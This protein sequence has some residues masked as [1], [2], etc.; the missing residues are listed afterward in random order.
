MRLLVRFQLDREIALPINHQHHL[1]G[2]VYR[3]LGASDADYAQ[4]LHEEGYRVEAGG[5]KRFKLF[6]FSTL[7][8][9][10]G[11]RRVEGERLRIGPGPVEWLLASPREEFLT[12][13]A[14]GLLTAG[15][16]V[17]VGDVPLTIAQVEALPTPAFAETTRFTCLTPVVASVP[18]ED[19][20][21]QYLRPADGE[22]FSLA[23]RHNLLRKCELLTGRPPQDDR[24][25]LTFDADY[26][27]R[28]PHGGT[29]K[30]TFKGIEIVGAFAP[31]QL[32]GSV[33][34]MQVAWNCGLGEKNSGGFGMVDVH[35]GV[36]K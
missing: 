14:T 22:K 30:V 27:A 34:L 1:M 2:L 29:K 26:L 25:T 19:R 32:T 15:T 12:H 20:S 7:R 36:D 16:A 11:R 17:Q 3:L 18:R 5:P 28:H 8:V 31:F 35:A 23:V 9:P 6:V 24:L 21:T 33:E 13:S 10:K 4:F